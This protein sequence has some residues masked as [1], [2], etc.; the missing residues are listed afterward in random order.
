MGKYI[1]ILKG[2]AN[3][4]SATLVAVGNGL[5]YSVATMRVYLYLYPVLYCVV[6]FYGNAILLCRLCT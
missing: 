4:G 2:G 5:S 1:L 6:L 3:Y